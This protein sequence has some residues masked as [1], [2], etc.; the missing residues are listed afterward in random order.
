M[1]LHKEK[2]LLKND[3]MKA[4][5]KLLKVLQEQRPDL[6]LDDLTDREI[7]L[8]KEEIESKQEIL[9][10]V[11]CSIPN[12]CKDRKEDKKRREEMEI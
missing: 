3:I 10:G 7:A 4:N 1:G 9:D 12:Y 6:S 11:L 8:L 2:E 5:E